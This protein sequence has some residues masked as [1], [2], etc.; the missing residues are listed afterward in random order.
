MKT[1]DKSMQTQTARLSE[2][3]RL[4]FDQDPSGSPSS[5]PHSSSRN[6]RSTSR[7]RRSSRS[8]KRSHRRR[9]HSRSSSSSSTSSTQSRSRSH[10]RCHRQSSR[11]RCRRHRHSPPRRYRARSRSYSPSPSSDRHH[12][13]RSRSRS[14]SPDSRRHR[15]VVGRYRS[16][17]SDSSRRSKS[18]TP[19]QSS[20]HLSQDEK[21]ELL[22]IAAENAV[23]IV[24]SDRLQLP[25]SVKRT[26]Q[27]E[28]KAALSPDHSSP[29]PSKWV[30]PEPE[31]QQSLEQITE[32]AS[33][34]GELSPKMSPKRK[35]ITFSINNTVAKPTN[36]KPQG[37]AEVK[38]TSRVD[39]VGS[40]K[41]YGQWIPVKTKVL[42][43]S[44][45]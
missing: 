8:T 1:T 2:G 23:K 16:R 43:S 26:L 35:P 24:G 33:E 28:E 6:S 41:P 7:D 32:M 4:I 17:P 44:K 39:I 15:G 36:G 34:D 30:R 12:T 11:H 9:R 18:R 38:V 5:S 20:V 25:E 21:R 37:M 13:R 19:E 29:V 27:S 31:P 10:P 42:L 3:L 40:K 45:Q 14:R 22:R